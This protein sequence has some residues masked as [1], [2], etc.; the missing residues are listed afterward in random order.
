[1]WRAELSIA[2]Q[3]RQA[4]LRAGEITQVITGHRRAE[5]HNTVVRRRSAALITCKRRRLIGRY[6][7]LELCDALRGFQFG[8]ERLRLAQRRLA[9][10]WIVGEFGGDALG[11]GVE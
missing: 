7:G 8:I 2:Q 3:K 11:I 1:Q 10:R 9:L 4:S 6:R 5:E